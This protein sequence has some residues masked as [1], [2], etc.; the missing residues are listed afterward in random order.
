MNDETPN[1]MDPQT[2]LY[3]ERKA[4]KEADRVLALIG[5][6][7]SGIGVAVGALAALGVTEF[8]KGN[9]ASIELRLRVRKGVFLAS[10][11]RHPVWGWPLCLQRLR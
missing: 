1:N 6:L 9:V 10:A 3:I 2:E 5:W 8:I 7:A 4:R 11:S